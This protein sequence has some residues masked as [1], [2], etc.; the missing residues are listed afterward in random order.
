MWTDIFKTFMSPVQ[1]HKTI[2]I[3]RWEASAQEEFERQIFQ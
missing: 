3:I 2:F 1:I